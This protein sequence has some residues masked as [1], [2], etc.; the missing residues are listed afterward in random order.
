MKKLC[1]FRS[2]FSFLALSPTECLE[3]ECELYDSVNHCCSFI[4]TKAILED[5]SS[6]LRK[7]YNKR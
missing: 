7:I 3:R 6:M 1:P 4:T 5:I 2:E